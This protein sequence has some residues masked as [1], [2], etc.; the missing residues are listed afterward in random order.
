MDTEERSFLEGSP[1]RMVYE[2]YALR[3]FVMAKSGATEAVKL[4]VR[5]RKTQGESFL[6]QLNK[7]VVG[8]HLAKR[9]VDGP[10]V[11]KMYRMHM[12]VSNK[13]RAAIPANVGEDN[14]SSIN[15]FRDKEGGDTV[16]FSSTKIKLHVC[17]AG[18][19]FM[20][21]SCAGARS[22]F[23]L[24][25]GD[26]IGRVNP[27]L[28][29]EVDMPEWR[30]NLEMTVNECFDDYLSN[31]QK[32]VKLG[33]GDCGGD[34]LFAQFDIYPSPGSSQSREVS[35]GSSN[36]L[37]TVR[38]YMSITDA[39]MAL[40]EEGI[41][42]ASLNRDADYILTEGGLVIAAKQ[43]DLSC[44]VCPAGVVLQYDCAV[45]P[46]RAHNQ[47]MGNS[48]ERTSSCRCGL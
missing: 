17:D 48:K 21:D 29:R 10:R 26:S 41:I 42:D 13:D 35:G 31:E 7:N 3:C 44:H 5:H 25:I 34:K 33:L 27:Y 45:E 30:Y 23:S 8:S 2:K 47:W 43:I 32:V 28:Y 46:F 11:P 9:S 19:W 20:Y 4:G 18:V 37:R 1:R 36:M 14:L 40:F 15:D 6:V 22:V 39:D 12:F 38:V 16:G 24:R